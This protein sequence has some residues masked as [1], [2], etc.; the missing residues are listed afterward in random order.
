[1]NFKGR[2]FKIYYDE[3]RFLSRE[4]IV[5][6][7]QS[8]VLPLLQSAMGKMKAYMRNQFD[9]FNKKLKDLKRKNAWQHSKVC[10]PNNVVL[11]AE[12]VFWMLTCS[13]VLPLLALPSSSVV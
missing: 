9:R 11:W 10:S 4:K 5:T 8:P 2:R 7:V 1:M 3:V 13:L 6:T 12:F